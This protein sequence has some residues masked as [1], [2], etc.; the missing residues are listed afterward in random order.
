MLVDDGLSVTQAEMGLRRASIK[1]YEQLYALGDE[2][3]IYKNDTLLFQGD[4]DK[5][6]IRPGIFQ[7][8]ASD[9]LMILADANARD[10]D[11]YEY[12]N[13]EYSLILKD[14]LSHYFTG[15][16]DVTNVDATGMT[17]GHIFLKDKQIS[18]CVQIISQRC[19]H[20]LWLE[21]PNILYFKPKN[22][23]ISGY[24]ALY[25]TNIQ[26]LRVTRDTF[27]KTKVIIRM[28]AGDVTRGTGERIV[29]LSD[30]TIETEDEANDLADAILDE[31]QDT[32]IRGEI[33][34]TEVRHDLVA[35]TTVVL[36]APEFGFEEETIRIM[37]VTYTPFSTKLT[38][39]ATAAMVEGKIID[40][41][42][43][44]QR[45]EARGIKWL[46]T[47]ESRTQSAAGCGTTCERDCQIACEA[48]A[49]CVTACQEGACQSICQVNEQIECV[50]NEQV[51]GTS[52][53]CQAACEVG[54]GCEGICQTECQADC[55][56]S[57]EVGC[58]TSCLTGCE[59]TCQGACEISCETT[60]ET[61]C[62]TT[63]QTSCQTTCETQCQS[64][65]QTTCETGC[66]TT[67]QEACL[68]Q[69]L[70]CGTV[71]PF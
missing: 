14:L 42:D 16:F 52:G 39:G 50:K 19:R 29:L 34:L 67:C 9:K 33:V 68:V 4:I 3:K 31:L 26:D 60:C 17:C 41:E 13:E 21:P 36:H 44:I 1:L 47:C 54:H 62:Q 71:G 43:R 6:T 22:T 46:F 35:G 56:L 23:V 10:D 66:E 61:T 63:C 64:G 70:C 48:V 12:A 28:A 24:R 45:I 40:F 8:Y 69:E 65:C 53:V 15:E 18:Q 55:Q 38:V 27:T 49:S 20:V 32:M 7:A 25:G 5:E 30:D 2:L 57:C 59:T 51:C 58:E 37:Q 11:H